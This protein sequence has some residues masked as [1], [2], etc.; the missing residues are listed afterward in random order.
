M[1]VPELVGRGYDV[2]V[3]D[4]SHHHS[5]NYTRADVGSYRQLAY[6]FQ[7]R[8]YNFVYHLAAEFGRWNGEDYYESLW[9][10]NAIGTKHLIRLQEQLGFKLVFFSS[11][12]VY[13]DW[14]RTM[15]EDVMLLHEVKQLNDYAMTKWVGEM[16]CLNSAAMHDTETV[17]V[18]LFNT[19]GPGEYYSPYRSVICKFIYHA[20]KNL[21]YTVYMGH[22]RT[23]TYVTD[24]CRTLA[25]IPGN[26][27][28]GEVYN[29][30]GMEYHDIAYLSN[31]ILAILGKKDDHV[32]YENSEAFTTKD[33]RVDVSKAVEDLDHKCLVKLEEGLRLTIDWMKGVY[34]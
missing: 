16:Q 21:P 17:R 24:T 10:T 6:L 33:K 7:E 28:P 13:G 18:R 30:G 27:K 20:L 22:H 9:R 4:L 23:S 15:S 29:I 34:E 5:D 19:Y 3:C 31:T 25:N 2:H 1:L 14:P 26:F 8:R 32:T 12:E 11:S